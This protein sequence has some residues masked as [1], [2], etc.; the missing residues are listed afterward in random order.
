MIDEIRDIDESAR[1]IDSLSAEERKQILS[2]LRKEKAEKEA[3]KSQRINAN[4]PWRKKI[5]GGHRLKF[6]LDSGAVKTILP[7]D[8]LPGMKIDRSKGGS[9]R[10]ASGD[11]IPNIGSTKLIGTG[12]LNGN[13]TKIITQVADITKPLASV[14]EMVNSGMLVIMH[15]SGGIAKRFDIETERKIRDL[16]KGVQGNEVIL[17][18]SGG[19]FTF[20]IDVKSEEEWKDP[21]RIA[22]PGTQRMQVDS[23][24]IDKSYYDSL[25]DEDEYSE[26]PDLLDPETGEVL[27]CTPCGVPFFHRP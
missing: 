12:A 17:E 25:W 4:P 27:K 15:K 19:A 13:P 8:A 26:M 11:V 20:E 10:V 14:D 21:K 5:T 9:F 16:V 18:R 1:A 6:V 23:Y 2:V 24:S 22:K 3:L 7:K